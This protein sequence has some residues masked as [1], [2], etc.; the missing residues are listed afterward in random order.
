MPIVQAVTPVTAAAPVA[1]ALTGS[2]YE[3]PTFKAR[4]RYYI[5]ADAAG[6]VRVQIN[7]GSRTIMEVSSVSRA[8]RSPIVPDDFLTEAIIQPFEQIVVRLTNTVAGPSDVFWRVE[9]TPIR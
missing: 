6:A 5:T 7:H 8:N 4:V 2:I 3:R 9:L 1:N